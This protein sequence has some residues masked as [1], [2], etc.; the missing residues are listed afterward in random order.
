MWKCSYDTS[1]HLELLVSLINVEQD[2]VK[3][4]VLWNYN[5]SL[6]VRLFFKNAVS[7]PN[8]KKGFLHRNIFYSTIQWLQQWRSLRFLSHRNLSVDLQLVGFDV[9]RNIRGHD[10]CLN[11]R[12]LNQLT[13]LPNWLIWTYFFSDIFFYNRNDIEFNIR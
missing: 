13:K 6:Q 10:L 1:H 5:R 2:A 3:E 7:S 12:I 9:V 4:I 11:K 8:I